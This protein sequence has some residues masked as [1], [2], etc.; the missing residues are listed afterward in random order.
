VAKVGLQLWTI[1]DE[2][3]RDLA[4]T[5]QRVGEVGY[6]G[7]E[8]FSCT[9]T[10]SAGSGKAARTRSHPLHVVPA[11][12]CCVLGSCVGSAYIGAQP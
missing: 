7:V 9:G 1:R 12:H 2:C 6:D 10:T 11:G 5:L 8:L 4:A 3:D